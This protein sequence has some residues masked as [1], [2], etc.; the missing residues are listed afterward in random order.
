MKFFNGWT[1]LEEMANDFRIADSDVP[2]EESILF[3]SYENSGCEGDAI[4]LFRRGGKLF[5]VR[6]SH[7]SCHGLEDQWEPEEVTPTELRDH[8]EFHEWRHG[9]EA[10]AAWRSVLATL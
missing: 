7:C 5:E 4:V 10:A 9:P 6:G 3:A 1:G 2:S 8:R